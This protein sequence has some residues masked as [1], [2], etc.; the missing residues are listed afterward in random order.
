M[1]IVQ[2]TSNILVIDEVFER[3][4]ADIIISRY[5]TDS[6]KLEPED[7]QV[8]RT[9]TLFLN[10]TANWQNI[11]QILIQPRINDIIKLFI[12]SI[13]PS[14][15]APDWIDFGF[16]MSGYQ[17][18]QECRLHIDGADVKN[19]RGKLYQRMVSISITLNDSNDG[20]FQFPAQ[21]VEISCRT[22][23][24]V[25][26]PSSYTHPHTV[27][28]VKTPRYVLVGWLYHPGTV[29]EQVKVA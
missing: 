18:G 29:E 26:F 21:D 24:A 1:K 12:E 14:V 8:R 9:Q 19:Y 3:H 23:R 28:P 7:W 13:H 10:E 17:P 4:E 6:T 2:N 15:W 5:E 16:V 25:I 11:M 20:A 27:A 22:G